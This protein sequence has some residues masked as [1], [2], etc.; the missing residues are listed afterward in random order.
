MK[1]LL[2]LATGVAAAL[3]LAHVSAEL[4]SVALGYMEGVTW[5]FWPVAL[6]S[7]FIAYLLLLPRGGWVFLGSGVEW[8]VLLLPLAWWARVLLSFAVAYL[9]VGI[10]LFF[11]DVAH[12]RGL[13]RYDPHVRGFVVSR[14]TFYA[15][16]RALT[17]AC[18]RHWGLPL[19]L[20]RLVPLVVANGETLLMLFY[21]TEH[22][23]T[24]APYTLAFAA[25]AVFKSTLFVALPSLE[26]ALLA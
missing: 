7:G 5:Y 13:V 8:W 25:Y 23:Y 24:F 22:S 3:L 15:T 4:T 14:S 2:W 1:V 9:C 26:E 6:A 19:R 21:G 17:A 12:A 20:G 11:I 18:V 10:P 16:V